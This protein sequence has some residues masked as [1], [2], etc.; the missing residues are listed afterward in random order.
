MDELHCPVYTDDYSTTPLIRPTPVK[1]TQS[2]VELPKPCDLAA[3][4]PE[5][6]ANIQHTPG[7]TEAV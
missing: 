5:E 7:D 3:P 6:V 1:P 4:D 2:V